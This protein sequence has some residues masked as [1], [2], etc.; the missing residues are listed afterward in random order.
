MASGEFTVGD[1]RRILYA[2]AGESDSGDVDAA[3]LDTEFG[4]LGY[5]SLALLEAGS[6]IEREYGIELSDSAL[7]DSV[8]PRALIDAV[9]EQ[10]TVSEAPAS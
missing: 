4:A 1:L 10:L 8:T 2:A 7:F 5:E 9:N 6:W 3:S